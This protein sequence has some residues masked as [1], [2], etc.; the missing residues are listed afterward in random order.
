[1]ALLVLCVLLSGVSLAY[2]VR[3]LAK[4]ATGLVASYPEV[5]VRSGRVIFSPKVP[6]SPA[7]SAGMSANRDQILSIDGSPVRGSL[8]VVRAD[9]RIRGLQPFPVEV[10]REGEEPRTVLVTPSFTPSRPDW[11]FVLAFSAALAWVAFVLTFR[12]PEEP[13]GLLLVLAALTYLV[14]TCV[15]P[16][17]YESLVSNS[18]IHLGKLTSWLLVFFGLY[19]PR[20]RGSRALR[21]AVIAGI[22]AAYALFISLRIGAYLRWTSTGE[23]QW[24]DRYRML[25]QIGNV[26]DGI[27][28]VAWAALLVSAYV[29]VELPSERRQLQWILAGILLALPP[30]FFFEQLPLILGQSAGA[31]VSLGNFAG[32]FLAF[33]PIFL[34]VGLTRHRMFNIRF[35]LSRYALYGSL[36][37]VMFILFSLL[38]LPLRDGLSGYGLASPSSDFLSAAIL[39]LAVVG[40]RFLS[41]L[42]ARI[43]SPARGQGPW[44]SMA[45]L[46]RRNLE[47]SLIIEHLRLQ[48]RGSL[49]AEKLTELRAILRGISAKIRGPLGEI[50][51]GLSATARLGMEPVAPAAALAGAVQASV[52]LEDFAR[53]LESLAGPQASIPACSDPA[54]II[55]AAVERTRIKHPAALFSCLEGAPARISCF[56]AE[57][58]EALCHVL[59][60]A[61]EAQEGC[62]TPIG[63]R[64]DAGESLVT[65]TVTDSGAGIGQAVKGKACRP[66]FTT[67]PGHQ[68]LGLYFARLIVERI[69]GSLELDG[70]PG[71]GTTVRFALPAA[72]SGREQD[73]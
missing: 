44:G 54:D 69:D 32:L 49:R 33:I 2:F 38:Y 66:F 39:L 9:A 24:L 5:V 68:G 45:E 35:L 64:A 55:R 62:R 57:L 13:A 27:A 58:I 37:L 52:R 53:A 18:L 42:G 61:V 50:S 21:A 41:R 12:I 59:E 20:P 6:F 70:R 8:D 22:L 11:V 23:E 19:F 71:E 29:T 40:L 1:V 16:F 30:Y 47:L 7:V 63:V 26:S 51:E 72:R 65:I 14:F 60:N 10:R 56:P 67:K 46:E 28:Y 34:M 73:A 17:Y 36:F 15:K 3:Y 31:R 4:P 48:S 43:L 25:G